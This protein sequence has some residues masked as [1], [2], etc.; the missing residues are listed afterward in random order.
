MRHHLREI[1]IAAALTAS[2]AIFAIAL[3]DKQMPPMLKPSP[4][5]WPNDRITV[6]NLGHATLLMN[7]LGV[8]V[9]TDPSLFDRVGLAFDSDRKSVV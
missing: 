1:A 4:V 9:I 8:R 7:F 3:A 5:N 6:S 2:V